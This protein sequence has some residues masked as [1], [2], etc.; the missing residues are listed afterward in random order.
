[1]GTPPAHLPLRR[2]AAI[3]SRVRSAI[4]SRSNWAK[5]NSTFKTSRP[6]DVA[7]L[8]C[9]DALGH[10]AIDLPSLDS[11]QEA[12]EGRPVQVAAGIAAVV[13]TLRQAVPAGLGLA[14]NIG[15]G[16]F[17]LGIERV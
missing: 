5:D 13:V 11:G 7:E 3:L 6:I 2:A 1:M 16:C 15:F 10:H 17:A 9:C 14:V 4:S 12:L 8:K